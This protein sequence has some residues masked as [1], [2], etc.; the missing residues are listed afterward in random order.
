[1]SILDEFGRPMPTLR[2]RQIAARAATRQRSGL[3][4]Q[5]DAAQTTDE[6]R[7][8]WR[9]ADNLSAAAAHSLEVRRTIFT[10]ARYEFANNSFCNG[11]VWTLAND[12]ITTGPKLQVEID[13]DTDHTIGRLI[14][15]HWRRWVKATRLNTKLRTAKVS[16]TV[17]GEPFLVATTNRR[18]RGPIKLDVRLVECDQISTPGFVDGMEQDAVDGIRFD[19]DGNPI[20]Y[21]E[22]RSHPGDIRGIVTGASQDYIPIPAEYVIHLFKRDRPG[23]ARGVS[24][25]TPALPLYAML[26]RL[27]LATVM[28]AESAADLAVLLKTNNT[29]E[30]ETDHNIQSFSTVDIERGMMTAL[31]LNWDA[32]GFK[33]EQP[34]TNYEMFRNALLQEIARCLHMPTN[35]ARGDSSRYNYSSARLDDQIYLHGIEVER[36]E[37][38]IECLDRI[39]EWWLNEAIF[40]IPE[41]FA[42]WMNQQQYGMSPVDMLEHS[43]SWKPPLRVNPLQDAKAS[44]E[45]IKAELLT[46]EQYFAENQ[47]D[48]DV[49]QEQLIRQRERRAAR[50]PEPPAPTGAE[51]AESEL[52][53]ATA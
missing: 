39:F 3:N 35:K 48:P 2:E 33:P 46:E 47:I 45:L 36:D 41:L 17:S 43:W 50:N 12:F 22:L 25:I 32:V 18:L 51:S 7:A 1:M 44:I 28:A 40:A 10:R 16:K 20:E 8:H 53:E 26:R 52:A 21:H 30:C 4:A 37:W 42:W 24:E 27:T 23:M 19:S 9:W 29:A 5:Y 13:D 31:P 49:H 38:E 6:N 14:E 11:M 34:T 15:K